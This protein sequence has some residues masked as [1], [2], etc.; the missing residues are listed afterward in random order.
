MTTKVAEKATEKVESGGAKPAAKKTGTTRRP[1]ARALKVTKGAAETKPAKAAKPA[2]PKKPRPVRGKSGSASAGAKKLTGGLPRVQKSIEWAGRTLTLETGRFARQATGS[3]LATYGQTTVLCTA[4]GSPKADDSV[5]FS[6]FLSV[7]YLTKSYAAGKIPGGFLKRESKPSEK[8]VLVSRLI[9]RPIR[10]LFPDNFYNEVQVV[11]TVLSYDGENDADMVAMVGASAAL[12]ISGIPFK[13]P[14]AGIRVGYQDGKYVLNPT[15]AQLAKSQMD[16][17]V[18]G[19][20]EGVLMVESEVAELEDQVVLDA[21]TFGHESIQPVIKM[22]QELQKEAGKKPWAA[23]DN[24]ALEKASE[25]VWKSFKPAI[26]KAFAVTDKQVMTTAL[27]AVLEEVKQ[28]FGEDAGLPLGDVD[29]GKAFSGAKERVLRD[30]ALDKKRIDGRAMNEVR[31]IFCETS[32][33]PRVH[34]SALFTRGETQALVTTTLGSSDDAQFMEELGD[35]YRESFMLHYNFPPF[36]VGEAGRM[37][38]PGRREVGHGKLAWRSIRPVLPAGDAFPY[39]LRVV[40]EILESNGSSSMATV[41]GTSLALMDA[42]VSL[43]RPVA[44]IAMGLVKEGQK[45]A[46]L[47]DITATEDAL[48]DMDFKVAGTEKGITA[49][50]MDIKITSITPALM[51]KAVEQAKEGRLHILGKMAEELK[52][53]RG[54]MNKNAPRA[55][56]LQVPKDKIRDIIGP[57]GSMIRS[58]C[59]ETDS[60]INIDD[61]TGSVNVFSSS[62]A[63]LDEVLKRLKALTY[64][65][66][67]GDIIEGKVADIVDFGA[68]VSLGGQDGLLHVSEISTERVKKVTDVLS[69]GQ[70]VRVKVIGRDRGKIKLSMKALAEE[71]S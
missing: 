47:S 20:Q 51:Q 48:G 34:G 37:G 17:V 3:I 13:G 27:E 10:P 8:E 5:G 71:Q 69:K 39:T 63:N 25:K 2:A 9:D 41:C 24:S 4:V 45:H 11:C 33:L 64:E 68:F 23:P 14:I 16:L 42:G 61:E 55:T 70:S 58:L 44:G 22:I 15:A 30:M 32:V 40:S 31:P 65:P 18:A 7:H 35:E 26:E 38:A 46:I 49:L 28:K 57:G 54:A 36:S 62:A 53:H 19:T 59:Q 29:L 12:S 67:I 6:P 1:A 43:L 50:Q 66:Q 52:A 60:Q 56:T 21:V